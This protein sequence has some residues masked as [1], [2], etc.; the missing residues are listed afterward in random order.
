MSKPIIEIEG[1]SKRFVK[2]IDFA[3]KI[4]N[5]M[6]AGLTDQVVRA[7]DGVNLT[8]NEGE[9]VGL[10]GESGCGK[11]TLGRMVAG[12]HGPDGGTHPLSRRGCREAGRPTSARRPT[13]PSR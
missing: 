12:H 10:V 7:V 5:M 3:G 13:S 8:I 9:V 6:G 11:S 4:A 2:R 1:V